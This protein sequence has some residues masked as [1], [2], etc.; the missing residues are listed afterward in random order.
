MRYLKL[1]IL[2]LFFAVQT[3]SGMANVL[4]NVKSD[5]INLLVGDQTR[6]HL[7][8][9]CDA[10]QQVDFPIFSD[11]IITG[12][13]LLQPVVTDTQYVN[14]KKRMT[15]TRHY[16]VTSFDSAFYFIPTF[17][18]YVDSVP[19]NS[20]GLALAFFMFDL[21]SSEPDAFIGPK[22]IMKMPLEWQDVKVSVYGGV[23]FILLLLLV[24]FLTAR[25]KDNKPIIRIIKVEPKVPA[26]VKALNDIEKLKGD[27]LSYSDDAKG[28]YTNLTDIIREYINERFGFYATEMTSTEIYN[29]LLK[30]QEKESLKDL[31]DLL[32]M[33]DLVKFAK[34][35]PMLNENDRNL[36]SAIDFVNDTMVEPSEQDKQ[37]TEQKVVVEEK[38]SKGAR[39]AL[40]SV[41]IVSSLLS[42]A[43][44]FIVIRQLYYLFF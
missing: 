20:D 40:L 8:V 21:E 7:E 17:K 13:E 14:K 25:Y 10:D 9:T 12:I 39:M 23:A 19:Y 1:F 37:P 32:Q 24:L 36:L 38:R 33:A 3:L 2:T 16:T 11:T 18:V 42:L 28:Y 31:L 29:E 41:I 15:I 43:A 5:S 4:V 27:R 34:F 35:K 44:L 22:N 6:I 26:H 30:H